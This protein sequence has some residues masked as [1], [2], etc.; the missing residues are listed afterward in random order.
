MG[1]SAHWPA[2]K[3]L[4]LAQ[5][6]WMLGVRFP[7][8]MDIAA[9]LSLFYGDNDAFRKKGAR[10]TRRWIPTLLGLE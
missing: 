7:R 10:R 2:E 6:C 3:V 9:E 5:K 1:A 8:D 4:G